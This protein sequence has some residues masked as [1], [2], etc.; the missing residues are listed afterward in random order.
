M[1]AAE[2]T[3]ICVQMAKY[4]TLYGAEI[5]RVEDTVRRICKAYSVHRPEIY[6]TPANFIITISDFKGVPVTN[7]V[8][9]GKRTTNLDRLKRLNDLSRYICSRRPDKDSIL[10]KISE[11]NTRPVYTLP[12][13]MISLFVSGFAYTVLAGGGVVEALIS[14][15]IT[16][17]TR[18]IS[19]KLSKV[20][21]SIFFSS[22]VC[23]A[24]MAVITMVLYNFGSVP[25]FDRIM[26]GVTTTMVPGTAFTNGMR[27]FISGDIYSGIHSLTDALITAVGLAVGTGFVLMTAMGIK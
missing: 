7:S 10:E 15:S 18:V 5:Y 4:M 1:T 26:I 25:R 3:Q 2:L 21:Q 19:N 8:S 9:I 24:V 13:V 20:T 14:G 17:V 27:D 12:M 23:S 22:I 11:I 6:A 16:S